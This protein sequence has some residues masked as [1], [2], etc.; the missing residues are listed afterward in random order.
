MKYKNK[1][2]NE[3]N[4]K[5]HFPQVYLSKEKWRTFFDYS[6]QIY[7]I[8][9]DR[10]FFRILLVCKFSPI[11]LVELKIWLESIIV[12]RYIY[13]WIYKKT[14]KLLLI[15]LFLLLHKSS[16]ILIIIG[17]FHGPFYSPQSYPVRENV[18]TLY[19][20][21]KSAVLPLKNICRNFFRILDGPQIFI[22]I[23]LMWEICLTCYN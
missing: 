12:R 1:R 13:I 17:K 6:P 9:I 16:P 18:R 23:P 11:V 22:L 3:R 5:V 20:K 14:D 8:Q 21:L 2:E 7:R 19:F 4:N 15:F 10:L